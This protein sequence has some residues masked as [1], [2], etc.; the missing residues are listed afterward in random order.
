MEVMNVKEVA[1]YL[2]CSE[3]KIR[4][5]VRDKQIPNFRIGSK[6]NFNKDTINRWVNG[7]EIRNMQVDNSENLAKL[8]KFVNTER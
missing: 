8:N 5:M 4:N 2:K 3:S 1:E 6:L 7:Q